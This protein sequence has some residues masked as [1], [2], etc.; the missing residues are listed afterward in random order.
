MQSGFLHGVYTD[1]KQHPVLASIAGTRKLSAKEHFDIYRS[2]IFGGLLKSLTDIYPV[3]KTL[4]GDLFFDAMTLAYIRRT[5]S[6]Q[7]DLNHY[8]DD[9]PEFISE[10]RPASELPYL[11]DMA[12]LEWAWHRAYWAADHRPLDPGSIASMPEEQQG[13]IVFRLPPSAT[14]L[15]SNYPL[16]HIR[17]VALDETEDKLVDLDQENGLRLMIWREDLELR[18]APLTNAEWQLLCL[19]HQGIQFQEVCAHFNETPTSLPLN[20]LLLNVFHYGWLAG[21]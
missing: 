1:E 15:E 20:K 11:P 19:F 13:E 6:R 5:P 3:C 10:F 9:F 2:S 18:M 12:R 8:G 14:L 17:N 7:P 16:L 21:F 4:V